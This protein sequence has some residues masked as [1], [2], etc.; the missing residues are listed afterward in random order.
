[1]ALESADRRVAKLDRPAP[2]RNDRPS[3]A[4]QL[5]V[6]VATLPGDQAAPDEQ[7]RKGELDEVSERADSPS[8]HRGPAL[9]VARVACQL[10]GA[11]RRDANAWGDPDRFDGDGE[12]G[13]LLSDRVGEEGA[14]ERRRHGEGDAGEP[15]AAAEVEEPKDLALDE[16]R[17][18]GEA[19]DDVADRDRRRLTDRGQVDCCVP[20]QQQADVIV[21]RSPCVGGERQAQL[22]ESG[23]EGSAV[24]GR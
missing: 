1:M 10:L 24:V 16:D 13:R 5:I 8:R 23:V 18:G 22:P 14:L 7:Q 11:G 19:V 4:L 17:P 9:P 2:E 12:K 3:C 6:Q 21:D 15:A 20:G